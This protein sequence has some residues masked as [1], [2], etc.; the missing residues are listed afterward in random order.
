MSEAQKRAVNLKKE[1][2]RACRRWG[3]N[4]T[5]YDGGLGFVDPKE[6]KIVAVWKPQ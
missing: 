4:L 2:E 3:L 1:I 5:I 6:N